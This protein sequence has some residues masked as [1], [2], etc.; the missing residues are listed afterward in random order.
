MRSIALAVAVF[1]LPYTCTRCLEI[2]AGPEGAA[3]VDCL[4]GH[5]GTESQSDHHRTAAA[6]H[7]RS[8][9]RSAADT[10]CVWTGKSAVAPASAP[11]LLDSGTAVAIMPA[12]RPPVVGLAAWDRSRHV[13]P[14]AH[15]PPIYIRNAALLI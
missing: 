11:T 3:S 5:H 9:D 4:A 10:C 7:G 12:A 2:P 14:L 15:A 13:V 1:W 6:D 8:H